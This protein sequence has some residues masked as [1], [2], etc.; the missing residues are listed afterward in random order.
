MK[1][2]GGSSVIKTTI[3]TG[4]MWGLK[5]TTFIRFLGVTCGKFIIFWFQSQSLIW[6]LYECHPFL[7]EGSKADGHWGNTR[8]R[9]QWCADGTASAHSMS[10]S[11]DPQLKRG[12][13]HK[14]D[15]LGS[16]GDD[17]VEG[18]LRLEISKEKSH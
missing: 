16:R 10:Y 17:Q 18:S 13:L 1:S 12:Q 2:A 5:M 14:A 8:M 9:T 4:S 11:F 6:A 7:L 3:I 15:K